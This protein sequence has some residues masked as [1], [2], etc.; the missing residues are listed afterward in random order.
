MALDLSANEPDEP[1]GLF[2]NEADKGEGRLGED[3]NTPWPGDLPKPEAI[4]AEG[5]PNGSLI[6][7]EGC[8]PAEGGGD[9]IDDERADRIATGEASSVSGDVPSGRV[10]RDFPSGVLTPPSRVS[11]C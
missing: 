5:G 7:E 3:E 11:R 8:R 2:E 4:P 1:G 9:W 10:G 6:G